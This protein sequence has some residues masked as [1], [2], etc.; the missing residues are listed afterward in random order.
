MTKEIVKRKQKTI[1]ERLKEMEDYTGLSVEHMAFVFDKKEQIYKDY[2][3][4]AFDDTYSIREDYMIAQIVYFQEG[5]DEKINLLKNAKKLFKRYVAR[6]HRSATPPRKIWIRAR[7]EFL[8]SELAKYDK[9]NSED[10]ES[11]GSQKPKKTPDISHPKPKG[12]HINL[13]SK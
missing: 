10:Y 3:R 11:N 12:N 7:I 4:G 8:K 5:L 13:T 9:K 2:K 1:S 6:K